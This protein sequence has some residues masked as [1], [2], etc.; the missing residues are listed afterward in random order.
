M[1]INWRNKIE[2]GGNKEKGGKGGKGIRSKE[3][4]EKWK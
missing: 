4:K 2:E 1:G 3:V